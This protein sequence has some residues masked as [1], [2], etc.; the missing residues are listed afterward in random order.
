MSQAYGFYISPVL[1]Y[2]SPPSKLFLSYTCGIYTVCLPVCKIILLY[3]FLASF[4]PISQAWVQTVRSLWS[5]LD[6]SGRMMILHLYSYCSLY[7]Y[8][9]VTIILYFTYSYHSTRLLRLEEMTSWF[10]SPVSSVAEYLTRKY[11]LNESFDHV[12][13]ETWNIKYKSFY[14]CEKG[15]R[16][17]SNTIS[18]LVSMS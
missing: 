12:D 1:S 4:W 11:L 3:I 15:S 10:V 17:A 5:F 7:K 13:K 6:S 14:N 8:F 18:T 9:W 16:K 2:S